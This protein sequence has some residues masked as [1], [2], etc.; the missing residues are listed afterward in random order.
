MK[1]AIICLVII[2]F[3]SHASV[4]NGTLHPV[5][6]RLVD[7]MIP[8]METEP[9]VSIEELNTGTSYIIW[10]DNNYWDPSED[11]IYVFEIASV[12][13]SVASTTSWISVGC[14]F[15][16]EDKLIT[17]T[18]GTCIG[19]ID[20]FELGYSDEQLKE[21]FWKVADVQDLSNTDFPQP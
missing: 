5:D 10:I 15:V 6:A 19:I 3:A 1:T 18:T 17:V 14:F 9:E 12:V 21:S 11:A 4:K 20:M 7:Q 13:G 2:V 16:F 8:W